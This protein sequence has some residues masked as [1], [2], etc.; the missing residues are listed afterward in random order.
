MSKDAPNSIARRIEQGRARPRASFDAGER[1][2]ETLFGLAFLVAA[3][4]LAFLFEP[5]RAFSLPLAALFVVMLAGV[6]R[7]GFAYLEATLVP[8]ELVAFPMLLLL[9]TPIVP[10]L[11]ALAYLLSQALSVVL[12][13]RSINRL[14][15]PPLADSWFVIGPATVLLAFGA[16]LPAWHW[17]PVYGLAFLAHAAIDC[18]TFAL[19][20]R[21]ATGTPARE[22]AA[23]YVRANKVAT[24]L[25][26]IAVLTAI[27]ADTAPV[28]VALVL[29]LVALLNVFARERDARIEQ[30]LELGRSYRGTALLLTD[31]L[32]DDD[33]YTGHH[34]HDVV[35]LSVSVAERMGVSE[36][37]RSETELG[38]L[39]HDIGKIAIPDSIINKPGK[40]DADEWAIMKTHTIEGQ[41]MLDRVGGMLSSVGVVVRASH[42]RYDGGGYPDGLAGEAIPL[43]ARIV[44]VCDSFNAMTTTRSYRKAMPVADAVAEVRRCSGTQF[45][46][47]VVEALLAVVEAPEWVL[48]VRE[49]KMSVP[50]PL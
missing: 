12:G 2:G 16:Q 31:L 25:W 46:P 3:L 37:V 10:L 38:A 30:T 45:D 14:V 19:R 27:A 5:T 26:P 44:A 22:L 40:L 24:L 4:A 47:A 6:S 28:T 11:V 50:A 17:L 48:T 18:V 36:E 32:E 13:Q 43:A 42:E 21:L 20:T 1:L 8:V 7:V 29:P 9:P 41:K 49:T 33:E 15:F 39:L 35:E 34:T 23:A